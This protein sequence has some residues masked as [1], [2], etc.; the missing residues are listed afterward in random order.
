MVV[1]LTTV[2]G[3]SAHSGSYYA[4]LVARMLVVKC[5][6]GATQNDLGRGGIEP[7]PPPQRSAPVYLHSDLDNIIV[8]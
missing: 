6:Q 1:P 4:K 7:L 5:H 2:Q 8:L 3:L